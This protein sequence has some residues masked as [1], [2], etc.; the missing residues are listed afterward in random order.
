MRSH[1]VTKVVSYRL[2]VGYAL[3]V[4]STFTQQSHLHCAFSEQYCSNSADHNCQVQPNAPILNIE[5]VQHHPFV[6]A[7]GT[8]T[9]HLPEPRDATLGAREYLVVFSITFDLFLDDRP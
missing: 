9:R 7:G 8:T 6:V 3:M 5:A 2:Q 1:V 4:L